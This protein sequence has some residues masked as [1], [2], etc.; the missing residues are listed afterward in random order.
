MSNEALMSFTLDEY[1]TL[2]YALETSNREFFGLIMNCSRRGE[3]VNPET[4]DQYN[5][6]RCLLHRLKG[7]I[8]MLEKGCGCHEGD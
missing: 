3:I 5:K 4:L 2:R 8:A 1:K 6:H 7:T